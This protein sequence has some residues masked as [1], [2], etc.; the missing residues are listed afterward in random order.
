MVVT[1]LFSWWVSLLLCL[2]D[3]LNLTLGRCVQERTYAGSAL[4]SVSGIH[5]DLRT[6]PTAGDHG[7]SGPLSF[8]CAELWT[9]G[10]MLSGDLIKA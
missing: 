10:R 2:I 5:W 3:S 7:V 9:F 8:V 1:A 4:P 6:Q